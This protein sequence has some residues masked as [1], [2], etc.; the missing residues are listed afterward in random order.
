M[1]RVLRSSVRGLL[2]DVEFVD[3]AGQG[4]LDGRTGCG[5]GWAVAEAVEETDDCHDVGPWVE[6]IAGG[7]FPL[8][9]QAAGKVLVVVEQV[10]PAMGHIDRADVRRYAEGHFQLSGRRSRPTGKQRRIVGGETRWIGVCQDQ[11]SSKVYV[12]SWYT[13]TS[14]IFPR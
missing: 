11:N 1:S 8:V 6:G 14:V 9:C 10:D 5:R 2:L 4:V 3:G 12:S 7:P 13:V